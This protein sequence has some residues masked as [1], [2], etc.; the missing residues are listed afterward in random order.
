MN[1]RVDDTNIMEVTQTNSKVEIKGNVAVMTE[2]ATTRQVE[3]STGKAVSVQQTKVETP[4]LPEETQME[5]IQQAAQQEELQLF[6][7]KLEA[8]SNTAS[9]QDC[10]QLEEDG[11][12]LGGTEVDTIVTEM[13]KIKMELAQAGADISI[14]GDMGIHPIYNH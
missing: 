9:E 13:D 6:K 14:F 10:S 4:F 5:K 2:E 12:S 1:I 11:F 7:K 8:V 3:A